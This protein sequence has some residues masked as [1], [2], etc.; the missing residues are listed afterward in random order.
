MTSRQSGTGRS[1]WS[2]CVLGQTEATNVY[3]ED[4]RLLHVTEVSSLRDDRKLGA[5]NGGVQLTCDVYRTAT[6]H[7]APQQQVGT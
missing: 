5:G 1:A 3:V 2:L 7:V 6:I 4:F